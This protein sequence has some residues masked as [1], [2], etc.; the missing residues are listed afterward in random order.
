MTGDHQARARTS[1]AGLGP[2]AAAI[3]S[4]ILPVFL[5]GSLSIEIRGELGY[6]EGTAGL[7]LATFFAS[8]AVVSSTVGRTVDRIGPRRGL[9]IALSGVV[10]VQ[11]VV[12]TLAASAPALAVCAG[13]AG[14]CNATAQLS[15][16]VFIARELP[17]HRQGIGFA[18]KQ[19]AMPGASLVA[20]LALP[21]VALTI[22]WRWVFVLGATLALVAL[23]VVRARLVDSSI[24][25]RAGGVEMRPDVGPPPRGALASLAVAAAFATAAAITLGGFFVESAIDAGIAT[26]IAGLAFAAGSIVSIVVRLTVGA[27][28]DRRPGNLLGVV[29]AMLAL[30]ALTSIWF[31]WRSPTAQFIGV[32]LA[33]GAGWAWPGLF[34]LSVVRAAPSFPGRATGITQTGTYI[35]GATGPVLFGLVAERYSFAAAWWVAGALGGVAAAA[36]LVARAILTGR[37]RLGTD[38]APQPL[39]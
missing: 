16:N 15:A 7:L 18:V 4:S 14:V 13:V 23:L 28:A 36:V 30:G 19:S 26:G 37:R 33:F 9:M 21:A 35:G 6:G 5:L 38:A 10:T 3:V 25:P 8:S 24:A 34:N 27:I 22:G 31:T 11:L 20:G 1:T 12:A 29:A 17:L 32:P 2:V 39:R